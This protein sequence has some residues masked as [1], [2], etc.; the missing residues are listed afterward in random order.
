MK[1]QN[2]QRLLLEGSL[3]IHFKRYL[4]VTSGYYALLFDDLPTATGM[5]SLFHRGY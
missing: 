1:R 2:L 5:A 4:F 3:R